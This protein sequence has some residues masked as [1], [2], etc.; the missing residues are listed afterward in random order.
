MPFTLSH[1]AAVVPFMRRRGF[2]PS[3]LVVG[4]MAPDFEYFICLSM[5]SGRAGHSLPG[6]FLLTVPA[7]LAVLWLYHRLLKEPLLSLLPHCIQS[8]A[9]TYCAP[10]RFWPRR[11]F[12]A[13][14]ESIVLGAFT[15]VAWDAFTHLGGC[16]VFLAP[17][18]ARPVTVTPWG[19]V[20]VHNVLQYVSS[21][22]G[23]GVLL[24]CGIGWFRRTAPCPVPARLCLGAREKLAI[25]GAL[26]CGAGVMSLAYG[27]LNVPFPPG[28]AQARALA[29]RAVPAAFSAFLT[30]AV[31]F[32]LCWRMR[33]L[34][35]R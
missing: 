35:K 30:L 29:G 33:P 34:Y 26:F 9:L 6:L 25:A 2:V 32:G 3:A 23:V 27:L 5:H 24:A 20:R 12:A 8:R 31:V 4:C 17:F 7:A 11:R 19:V 10:F 14:L 16:P 15:H 28:L 1:P 18:L 21:L 13:I 22:A